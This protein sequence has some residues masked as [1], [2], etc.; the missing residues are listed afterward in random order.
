MKHKD[1]WLQERGRLYETYEE[2]EAV[3]E[4]IREFLE[5]EEQ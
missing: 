5:K 1:Q 3:R 2:A 4:R